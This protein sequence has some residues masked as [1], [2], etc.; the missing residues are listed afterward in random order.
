MRTDGGF[1][2]LHKTIP[3]KLGES[4][5]LKPFGDVHRDA[6]LH[7]ETEWQ[8]WLKDQSAD[9]RPSYYL[10]MGDYLDFC[11]AHTRALLQS[12]EEAAPEISD[13]LNGVM[14]EEVENF[15]AE[16]K[17]RI[18]NSLIGLIGGNHVPDLLFRDNGEERRVKAD[19]HLSDILGV[20]Y[21]GTMLRLTLELHDNLAGKKSEVR[22]VLH[23]GAGGGQTNGASVNRVARMLHGWRAHIALMGD[24][25]KRFFL[26]DGQVLDGDVIDGR[27]VIVSETRWVGRTGSFLKGF[28]PGKS[29][30]VVDKC[31]NPLSL[32]TIEIELKLR[33]DP[34]TGRVVVGIG[35]YLPA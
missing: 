15:A 33:Q 25:H 29:S 14:L 35:G 16:L 18:S 10:G 11:R 21:F 7:A 6:D 17:P 26:P 23:H 32:G 1:S 12:C 19:R 2:S 3:C 30:Y 5:W 13:K 31:F 27:E 24:D 22:I 34:R 28:A 9:T 8:G 20:P 4:V